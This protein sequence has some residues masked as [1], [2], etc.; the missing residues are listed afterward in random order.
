[1][2]WIYLLLAGSHPTLGLQGD[3]KTHDNARVK[4]YLAKLAINPA[5]AHGISHEVGSIDALLALDHHRF[6]AAI[7]A[8]V[9]VLP[10]SLWYC[11]FR[12]LPDSKPASFRAACTPSRTESR[13]GCSTMAVTATD[14]CC[15]L[16]GEM[17][18]TARAR[19]PR[20]FL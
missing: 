7:W 20:A 5:L 16:A 3:P 18:A 2:P 15:A 8:A 11:H 12:F 6:V 14:F 13:A 1:M 17:A 10:W 19:A 4:R 9:P